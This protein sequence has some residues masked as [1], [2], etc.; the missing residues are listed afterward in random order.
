MTAAFRVSADAGVTIGDDGLTVYVAGLP[1][2][3]LLVL[4]GT[5]GIIWVEATTGPAA[6]WVG[7]VAD[8]VGQAED[9]VTA[10]VEAFVGDLCDRGLLEPVDADLPGSP[11]GR[12]SGQSPTPPSG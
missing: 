1:A 7:R 12:T 2:G 6:G 9:D 4:A 3:P 11:P 10:D 8:A 5:A